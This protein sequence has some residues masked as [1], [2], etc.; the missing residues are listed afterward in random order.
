M[1][2]VIFTPDAIKNMGIRYTT[3]IAISELKKGQTAVFSCVFSKLKYWRKAQGQSC[4]DYLF[5]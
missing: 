2:Q 5:L 4:L 1:I 3:K